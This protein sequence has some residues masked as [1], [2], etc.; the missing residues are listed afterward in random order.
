M[1][2]PLLSPRVNQVLHDGRRAKLPGT[3]QHGSTFGI[4][5]VHI[6]AR[7]HQKPYYFLYNSTA[8]FGA[9]A[10]PIAYH[11]GGYLDGIYKHW[12]SLP[13][14]KSGPISFSMLS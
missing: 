6:R 9:E 11:S 14:S 13:L 4:P 12:G 1:A 7:L 2:Q 8:G 5:G 3:F 10:G